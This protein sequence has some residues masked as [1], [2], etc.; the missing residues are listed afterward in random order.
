MAASIRE[1][2]PQLVTA[3]CIFVIATTV[4]L[5]ACEHDWSAMTATLVLVLT[6]DVPAL[7]AARP[8]TPLTPEANE[9]LTAAL[10]KLPTEV[11]VSDAVS[12]YEFIVRRHRILSTTWFIYR[13]R[14]SSIAEAITDFAQGQPMS[15]VS[16]T[17]YT[18]RRGSLSARRDITHVRPAPAA[19]AG[20]VVPCTPRPSVGAYVLGR[21]FELW[22][23]N[24]RVTRKEADHL[25]RQLDRAT[26]EPAR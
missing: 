14:A 6:I 23:G 24:T 18:Y 11:I 25:V 8:S 19:D 3:A 17:V 5:D 26:H 10:Q 7:V 12:G 9:A 20:L 13:R 22:T 2:L 4:I 15:A 21:L 16:S 1:R